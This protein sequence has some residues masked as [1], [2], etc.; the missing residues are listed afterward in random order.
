VKVSGF[1]KKSFCVGVRN[2]QVKGQSCPQEHDVALRPRHVLQLGSFNIFVWF[3]VVF[4][5]LMDEG[6]G[7][8]YYTIF[9]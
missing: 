7:K 8:K 6:L 3:F 5:V 1:Y 2:T 4:S 9:N